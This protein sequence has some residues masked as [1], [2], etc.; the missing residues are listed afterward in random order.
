MDYPFRLPDG[1]TFVVHGWG[2][3]PVELT[4]ALA[5]V[6]P[7]T[8]SWV[9][10]S[11]EGYLREL[12]QRMGLHYIVFERTSTDADGSR[13]GVMIGKDRGDL[14]AAAE[15]W[16]RR[17]DNPGE[18]LGYPACCVQ[19]YSDWIA[20]KAAGGQP[21]D[22]IRQSW[23]RTKR[24]GALPFE[25]N[26]VFYFYSRIATPALIESR[27]R[28]YK[29]NSGLDLESM[30]IVPWHPCSYDCG[31][32]LSRGRRI[33]ETMRRV[34]P[35][36]A[37]VMKVCLSKPVL[38]WDWHRFAVLDGACSEPG[39]CRYAGVR[40]PFSLLD[41]PALE[42]L[43]SGTEVRVDPNR[44]VDVF[45]DGRRVGRLESPAPILLAFGSP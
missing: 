12:C 22:V 28:I 14:D 15:S 37:A 19:P 26:N 45:K 31:E 29:L 35:S 41:E 38:F 4:A 33:F 6:K 44:G 23:S 5:G 43:R 34:V 7:A 42:L 9:R 2:N 10:E 18:K 24:D 40:P 25:L 27:S 32:S 8:H 3:L 39:V 36:L 30:N 17:A 20:E 21:D 1:S 11:D 16:V 13:L